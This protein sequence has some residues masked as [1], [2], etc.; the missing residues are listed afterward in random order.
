MK[1]HILVYLFLVSSLF[2]FGQIPTGYYNGTSGLT[3]YALKTKLSQITGQGY[4]SHSYGDL[5]QEYHTS[6]IDLYYEND[7]TILDIYSENP[8]GPDS[9]EYTV[10]TDQCGSYSGEGSCYN[11]EHLVPQ[12]WFNEAMPMKADINHIFP[13]DGYVNNRRS[14]YTFGEVSNPTYTSDN[15]SKLGPNTYNFPGAFT[16]T[17]FDPID[18]FKGD[19]A[20]AYLY[21]A[22]RYENQVGSWASAGPN[23]AATFDGSSDHVFTDW[24]L[25]MLLKWNQEDPVSQREIDRNNATYQFQGNRN[26]FIDHP[27]Y[28][29]LIWGNPSGGNGGNGNNDPDSL[30]N[31]S[32]FYANFNNCSGV[33]ANFNIINELSAE[34][35]HCSTNGSTQSGAMQMYGFANGQQDP[36]LDWLITAHPINF[37][38]N[39]HEKLSF[40]TEALHGNTP[41]ELVYSSDYQGYGAPSSFTWTPVP[42]VAIPLYPTGETDSV[43]TT[44]SNIDLSSIVGGTIYLAF[45]YDNTNGEDATR[46][47]VDD[48]R[49]WNED[50]SAGLPKYHNVQVAV[51]PN[52]VSSASFR[53]QLSTPAPF[54]F[55]VFNSIGERIENGNGNGAA[56]VKTAAF[57]KG[58]YTVKVTTKERVMTKKIIIE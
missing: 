11:R 10:S 36:S 41:L 46:W 39:A 48:F 13:V 54:E 33:N 31:H 24:M 40:Y 20:R 28:A 15:G 14:N 27:E 25:D 43:V 44:F 12:S 8:S 2:I 50:Q 57:R 23:A 22:T 9:Y 4:I 58:I 47:T 21:M 49:I 56:N 38:Q 32:I 16:G 53:I 51:Y 3:G 19:I 34:N 55:S 6:D 35:W 42:Q 26:P 37:N 5:W 45:K 52:P 17:V 1:K 30:A 18:A 7:G 29:Q